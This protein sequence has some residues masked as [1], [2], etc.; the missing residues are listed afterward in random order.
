MALRTGETPIGS[1]SMLGE[2]HTDPGTSWPL[3]SLRQLK[4]KNVQQGDGADPDMGTRSYDVRRASSGSRSTTA[5][6]LIPRTRRPHGIRGNAAAGAAAGS[7]AS[8]AGRSASPEVQE[9]QTDPGPGTSWPMTSLRHMKAAS[10]NLPPVSSFGDGGDSDFGTH[11]DTFSTF[12]ARRGSTSSLFPRISSSGALDMP[13][14]RNSMPD[15]GMVPERVAGPDRLQSN[16]LLRWSSLNDSQAQTQRSLSDAVSRSFGA[17]PTVGS[18]FPSPPQSKGPA[19][20]PRSSKRRTSWSTEL[21]PLYEAGA[22]C[23]DRTTKTISGFIGPP[24]RAS[25]GAACSATPAGS[26]ERKAGIGFGLDRPYNENR[27]TFSTCAPSPVASESDGSQASEDTELQVP[28]A[29]TLLEVYAGY[30]DEEVEVHDRFMS[31]AF[32]RFAVYGAHEVTRELLHDALIHMGF[33]TSTKQRSLYLATQLSKFQNFDYMDFVGYVSRVAVLERNAIRQRAGACLSELPDGDDD[34]AAALDRVQ[35]FLRSAGVCFPYS[36]VEKMRKA[37]RLDDKRPKDMSTNDLLLTL[38]ACRVDEGFSKDQVAVAAAIFRNLQQDYKVA[39]PFKTVKASKLLEGLLKFTGLYTV[40]YVDVLAD[41][42]PSDSAEQEGICFYEFLIWARRLRDLMLQD[43]WKCFKEFDTSGSGRIQ[44]DVAILIAERFGI[45]ML[46]DA[47]DELLSGLGLKNDTTLD[48]DAM[49]Q[50]MGAAR[51][52]HGFT[53]SEN[54]E[55]SAAFQKFNYHQTGEL[56]QLQVLDLIRYLGNTTNVDEVSSL[57]KRV[58]FNKNGSMDLHEFLRL[59]RMM[60]EQDIRSAR[61]SFDELSSST[62]QMPKESVKDALA[63]QQLFPQESVLAELLQDMQAEVCFTSFMHIY[64]RCRFRLNLEFRKRGGFTEETVAE[65]ESLWNSGGG[66]ESSKK[67]ATINQ[68][69]W[70]FTDSQEVPVCTKDGRQRFVQRVQAAQEAAVE[71]GVPEE[72]AFTHVP[73]GSPKASSP[74]HGEASHGDVTAIGFF[75]FVH[76]IRGLVRDSEQ[77]VIKREKEA[78]SA[79]RFPSSEAAEFRT[80]F[81]D[82]AEQ[83]AKKVSS[84]KKRPGRTGQSVDKLLANLTMVPSIP[85]TGVLSMLKSI[86]VNA[87]ASKMAELKDFLTQTRS[88]YETDKHIIQFATFLRMLRWMLDTDF[89][90]ICSVMKVPKE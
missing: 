69:I 8:A 77:D 84:R 40:D 61:K 38:A 9:R 19:D 63:K 18:R 64:D 58:D 82:L 54:E 45:S 41:I 37:A 56:T 68:L 27:E 28:L 74:K 24:S 55:L 57:I 72:E 44:L 6:S 89:A 36:H 46:T 76:L 35:Q 78:V 85:E 13:S 3:A 21:V 14:R 42:L 25:S 7:S 87:T 79:A 90:S 32:K 71:A 59:M 10:K 17:L 88:R 62:G 33:L 22:E 30:A 65:I 52:V 11:S 12:R 66:G 29:P 53:R 47:V 16:S 4:A 81:S 23:S 26:K 1:L 39:A 48:F 86:G 43:L 60:R 49:V 5:A 51:A 80:V 31:L 73:D 50:F 75:T 34:G 83:E 2:R 70:M 67:F 15:V 20:L